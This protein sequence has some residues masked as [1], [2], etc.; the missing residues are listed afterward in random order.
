M[1]ASQEL[2]LVLPDHGPH[3]FDMINVSMEMAAEIN[4]RRHAPAP[5]WAR[6]GL[7]EFDDT[8]WEADDVIA[9]DVK[10]KGGKC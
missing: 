8:R 4:S 1:G 5:I 2:P 10:P 6:T 3:G 7:I 9:D